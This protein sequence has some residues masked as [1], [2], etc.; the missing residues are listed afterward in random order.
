MIPMLYDSTEKEFGRSGVI[1]FLGECISCIVT[2]ELNGIYECEFV[3]PVTGKYYSEIIEGRFIGSRHDDKPEDIQPYKIYKKSAPLSGRV[4]FYAHHLSYGASNVI[5]APMSGSN[6]ASIMSAFKSNS[7]NANPYTFWSSKGGNSPFELT[8]PT[9]MRTALMGKK[10]SVLSTYGGEFEFDKWQIKLHGSRGV[11]TDVTIRYG[12]NLT[13]IDQTINT[14]NLYNAIIPYWSGKIE[15]VD[16]LI[17]PEGDDRIVTVEDVSEVKPIAKDF[18]SDFKN[19]PEV[20]DLI[21]KAEQVLRDETPW[22]PK[23]N[24]KVS[25]IHL[26]QTDEY[27]N[28]ASLQRVSIGDKVSVYYPQLGVTAEDFEVIKTVYNVLDE[29]YDSM[30][31]GTVLIPTFIEQMK[32]EQEEKI[33]ENMTVFEVLMNAE[34]ERATKLLMNP[35]SSHVLFYKG[36]SVEAEDG[37][38]S[39]P[40]SAMVTGNGTLEDPEGI[41][42]M[43]TNDPSTA[44]D[45]LIINKSGIGFS[46]S[47]INGPYRNSWTL[48]GRFTTDFIATWEIMVNMIRLYGLMEVHEN[49]EAETDGSGNL[50]DPIGGYLGFGYGRI[51]AS[52]RTE[53]IMLSNTDNRSSGTPTTNNRYVI[54]TTSGVR[55]TAGDNSF[56]LTDNLIQGQAS[57]NAVLHAVNNYIMEI[58]GDLKIK[59]ASI[60]GSSELTGFTAGSSPNYTFHIGPAT[61]RI[62]K[63]IVIG[64]TE[65]TQA[66]YDALIQRIV[67]LENSGGGGGGGGGGTAV[68]G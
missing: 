3:Y 48:D 6:P 68:F 62:F 59:D 14:E 61:L 36:Q 11:K 54:A 1:C 12:K 5:I 35:G 43:D 58:G 31:L 22:I 8:V 46:E 9:S 51:D 26:W 40:S 37:S 42:I 34:I 65:W 33:E 10:D 32:Q 44:Q 13:G 17:M 7:I 64:G 41:L 67:A 47:G 38:Y 66:E 16:V 30:E 25:F 55:M 53:G 49:A 4:T 21:A 24:I 28:V 56:Y 18:S 23:E 20:S 29:R 60:S 45:V 63:G 57:G 52:T 27:E 19:A 50:I 2:E 15:G 39:I